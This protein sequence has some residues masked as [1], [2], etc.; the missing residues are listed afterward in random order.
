MVGLLTFVVNVGGLLFYR[1]PTREKI[2]GEQISWD[3]KPTTLPT[4]LHGTSWTDPLLPG[5][6][7]TSEH[8][9]LSNSR[10]VHWCI[11]GD[12]PLWKLMQIK[13][14]WVCL[15]GTRKIQSVCTRHGEDFRNGLFTL[16]WQPDNFWL[17][18]RG[19]LQRA[20]HLQTVTGQ[21][22]TAGKMVHSPN[23]EESSDSSPLFSPIC[24]Y[25]RETLSI[26]SSVCIH[27]YLF[28]N[29]H[30][31][32]QTAVRSEST[33]QLVLHTLPTESQVTWRS[34]SSCPDSG[35]QLRH[36]F[37]SPLPSED[38]LE[39]S[40]DQDKG[41]GTCGFKATWIEVRRMWLIFFGEYVREMCSHLWNFHT[42]QEDYVIGCHISFQHARIYLHRYL[43]SYINLT[44]LHMVNLYLH[45]SQAPGQPMSMFAPTVAQWFQRWVSWNSLF[46]VVLAS[47]KVP[48]GYPIYIFWMGRRREYTSLTHHCR[49]TPFFVSELGR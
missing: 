6:C 43:H 3:N 7:A 2:L 4:N 46:A 39:I 35:G 12:E 37:Y 9:H 29:I 23:P 21:Q 48:I 32:H 16:C 17:F 15:K 42:R 26:P 18:L 22:K 8:G 28:R 33:L 30:K 47:Q 31:Q 27:Y 19:T 10:A 44:S 14:G 1:Y 34:S 25:W 49:S 11:S 13:H 38:G 45:H 41:S 36:C 24:W 20:S 40:G 5:A